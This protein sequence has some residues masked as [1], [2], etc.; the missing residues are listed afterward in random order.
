MLWFPMYN[1]KTV[2]TDWV[3]SWVAM[4]MD[5]ERRPD[6]FFDPVPQMPCQI[7]QYIPQDSLCVGI[8]ICR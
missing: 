6:V 1:S 8:W 2:W 3:T 5:G 4:L 7:L